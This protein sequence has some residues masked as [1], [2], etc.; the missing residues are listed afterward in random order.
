MSSNASIFE[1]RGDPW[2]SER[3][4]REQFPEQKGFTGNPEL[5]QFQCQK[6]I[7]KL[8]MRSE[9]RPVTVQSKERR[10]ASTMNKMHM[11]LLRLQNQ[12]EQRQRQELALR[13][14]DREE[15]GG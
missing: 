10:V 15:S 4:Q 8:V 1:D 14:L 5:D 7:R 3:D 6:A 13:L 9:H 11:E 2:I 12:R